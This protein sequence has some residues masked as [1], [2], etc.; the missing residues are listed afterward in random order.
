LEQKNYLN[1]SYTRYKNKIGLTVDGKY[2]NSFIL[3]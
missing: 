1:D 2:L 3:N